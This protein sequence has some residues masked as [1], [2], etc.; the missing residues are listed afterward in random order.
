MTSLITKKLIEVFSK[1]PN[2]GPRVATRFVYYLAHQP[3]EKVDEFIKLIEDLK[4]KIKI[5]SSC[6]RAFETA[7][8]ETIEEELCPICSDKT[9]DKT[10]MCVV[11]KEID[12]ETIEKTKKFK[13]IYF[14]LGDEK[15][16]LEDLV[17][18]VKK[19]RNEF[20][21]IILALNPTTKGTE[22]ALKIKVKLKDTGIK[23]T[24]LGL[25][26]P[27]GAE[28]EYADE[29]TLSSALESRKNL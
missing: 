4:G 10:I 28:L 14:V 16:N 13:G 22:L 7:I 21:E 12:L 9:R 23:I 17:E 25:G 2:I 24:R 19:L 6:C 11:E 29:E 27:V 20:R 26:L 15:K 8:E 5:C 18:R 3:K 1:F